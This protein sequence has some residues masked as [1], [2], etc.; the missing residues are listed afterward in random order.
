MSDSQLDH[1]VSDSQLDHPVS[2]CIILDQTVVAVCLSRSHSTMTDSDSSEF[3]L[4][5]FVP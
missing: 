4:L 3:E 2:D 1:P 5:N